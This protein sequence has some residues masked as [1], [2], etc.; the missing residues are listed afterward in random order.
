MRDVPVDALQAA[1]ATEHAAVWVYGLAGAF[2]PD[3]L[4]GQLRQA[5]GAHQA[6]RDA[7]ERTLIDAGA[8]P[9][10]AEPGYLMPEPVT[11]AASALRLLIIAETDT[12]AAWRSVLERSPAEPIQ[13]TA[14]LDALTQ[15]AVRATRWRAV[16]GITPLTVPFP[17]T[18]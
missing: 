16:A 7:T 18:P 13:R 12:A 2:L 9:V 15:A 14:A 5:A 8:Q 4:V 3:E 1:L 17:G 11:D 10:P 6:R